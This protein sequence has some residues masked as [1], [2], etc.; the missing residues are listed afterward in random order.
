[1]LSWLFKRELSVASYSQPTGAGGVISL[2]QKKGWLM[3][4]HRVPDLGP[5]DRLAA[6]MVYAS[7][8]KGETFSCSLKDSATT[9]PS[10]TTLRVRQQCP[11]AAS[12]ATG[13]LIQ[14]IPPILL[15]LF[16]EGKGPRHKPTKG[17][18]GGGGQQ[19][20]LLLQASSMFNTEQHTP[21]HE[22]SKFC[23]CF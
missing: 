2:S 10:H 1:M 16:E 18:E 22:L 11:S 14:T 19:L 9:L 7:S 5:D 15:A 13:Q 23:C 21:S 3:H 8:K 12:V 6:T 20:L 4:R 17:G